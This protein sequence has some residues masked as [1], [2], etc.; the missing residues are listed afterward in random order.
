MILR[1][2][3]N[4]RS[5]E[6]L[7]KGFQLFG[8]NLTAVGFVGGT[9]PNLT[10]E[11]G[12]IELPNSDC[13]NAY[14]VVGS[15]LMGKK[16]FF[17]VRYSGFQWFNAVAIANYASKSKELWDQPCPIFVRS[18]AMEGQIGPVAGSSHN[19]LF[20]RMPGL[21]IF[22]PITPK[23][24]E[25][26]YDEFMADD[27]PY[28]ISEHRGSWNNDKE[29]PSILGLFSTITFMPLGITRFAGQIAQETL[30]NKGINSSIIHTFRIKP[31][32][33]TKKEIECLRNSKHIIIIDDDYPD[34]LA[35]ALAFDIMKMVEHNVQVHVL[36]LEERT[37]GFSKEADVL[38]PNTE[39]ILEFCR[40]IL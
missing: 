24:Y 22:A 28:I 34:G 36:G 31:F 8:Q 23:E 26:C 40:K 25:T 2:A 16:P 32:T 30:N 15:A 18:I 1:Q 4:K 17:V 21:K 38:P 12:L 39:Q 5:V 20:Y 7:S 27:E 6:H 9:V 14:V 13:S 19:S 29:F 37:A 10:E 3:I 33:L 35:K 11:Q